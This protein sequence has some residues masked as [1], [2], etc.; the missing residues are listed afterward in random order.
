VQEVLDQLSQIFENLEKEDIAPAI[1]DEDFQELVLRLP[2]ALPSNLEELYR[3][4]NGIKDMIPAYDFL[5]LSDAIFQYEELIAFDEDEQDEAFFSKTC[6]PIF[7]FEGS[8]F[9]IDCTQDIDDAIYCF[10][11]EGEAIKNYESLYQMLQII[12]DAYLSRAYYIEDD[13]TLEN[14]VLLQKITH[15][16]SSKED[17]NVR[18][19]EWNK[20]CTEIDTLKNSELFQESSPE[21]NKQQEL[22]A[23]LGLAAPR[24]LHKESLIRRLCDTYDERAITFLVEFLS[25]D[26]P[27]IIAK[28]AFGL[29]EL[30]AREQLPELV[31]LTKHP[32][33]AVRNLATCAIKEIVSPDDQL[34]LEPLLQ[35]LSDDAALVRIAAAQALGQLR[36]PIAVEPLIA[37]LG[38]K[39]SGV[40]IHVIA[41][42]GKIG[43]VRA[44]DIL[45]QGRRR[46]LPMEAQTIERAIHLIE[47]A[48]P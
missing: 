35:L 15:K 27:A 24:D 22:S 42:L 26:N 45:Q 2:F 36:N 18:E 13:L 8:Y 3:W 31:N 30:R 41:T 21:E 10:S 33:E 17:R 12:A 44:I 43:D 34:L 11:Y 29:G 39:S 23:L 20:L 9:F 32:A 6:L 19:L 37:L 14:P 38:D 16:Y 40:R 46:V 25:D 5:S 47:K 28:A 4:R 7:Q 1:L 48:N